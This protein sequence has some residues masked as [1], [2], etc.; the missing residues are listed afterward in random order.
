MATLITAAALRVTITEALTHVDAQGTGRNVA[1]TNYHDIAN[2]SA[3]TSQ[4]VDVTTTETGLMSFATN[5][6]TAVGGTAFPAGYAIG[7][8]DEDTVHY[9]RIT[10]KDNT[11]YVELTFKNASDDE[12]K[13]ILD[14]GQSFSFGCF[15][16]TGVVA[17]MSAAAAGAAGALANLEDI[18]AKA[19]TGTV[20]LDVF[21]AVV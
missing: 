5:N 13:V 9:L 1:R 15:D 6:T 14:K 10:N 7:H 4:M 17:T 2:V 3:I 20:L 21:V 18:T 8:F 11:N 12:F 19:N 16:D